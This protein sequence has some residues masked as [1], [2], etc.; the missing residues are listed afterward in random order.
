MP[1]EGKKALSNF[2]E[3]RPR[4]VAVIV[5]DN[6]PVNALKQAVRAGLK[7]AF[8]RACDDASIHA[9]VLTAAGRPF[10][11]GADITEFD[12]PP[13][14]PGLVEVLDLMDASQKPI[15][16]ALF[17]TP[18]GGGLEVALACHYRVAAP[19]TWLG[20]PEIKLGILPS[21]GGTQRLPRLIGI[22]KALPMILSGDPI[23]AMQALDY[24]LVDEI[25]EGDVTE[26]AIAFARRV[27]A[28]KRPL[29]RARDMD[30]KIK[31]Y[32]DN[33]K[34]FDEVVAKSVKR[35]RGLAAPAAAIECVRWSFELPMDEAE[36]RVRDK[37]QELRQ[38]DQSKAQRHIF[39]AEHE[40]AKVPDLPPETKPREIKR[41]AVIG[42]GTMGGGIS[43]CFAN[44]GI[45]VTIVETSREALERGLTTVSKNY[46]NTVKRGG[47]K[48]DDME[49][50]VK[51][52]NGTTDIEAV[53]DADI[54]VEAVFEEMD[55]K[56]QVFAKLDKLAKP[57]AVLA[58]NTSYLNVNEIAKATERPP[59]VLGMHF[60][61]P[62]NVMRLLEIVRGAATA[63]DVL[64]T[65]IAVGRKIGKVPAVVGVCHGFVGNRMLHTRGIEAERRSRPSACCSK[66]RCP[67][68]STAR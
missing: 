39:F 3:M 30:E 7:D 46:E 45:P 60:F 43:M 34:L 28:E 47:L 16:A 67:R 18:L 35:T 65:A 62:A 9:I 42:A 33:P 31:P 20:L 59:S 64:A 37:F 40:A 32:R 4:A 48:A 58:T 24:G 1:R 63:P 23:P 6:P 56:K 10:M 66:A 52:M 61:S 38:G 27:L 11:A 36:R 54:V 17:G 22:D 26:G 12:K 44:A 5:L 51:L 15:V 68:T 29:R 57:N 50:R 49:R 21:A 8:T 13:R 14:P 25:V 53:R 55:L 19:S 41:A 2:V